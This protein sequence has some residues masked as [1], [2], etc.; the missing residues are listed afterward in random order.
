MNRDVLRF[1]FAKHR[2]CF[3]AGERNSLMFAILRTLYHKKKAELSY[4]WFN[5]LSVVRN[6]IP[7]YA[8]YSY[9]SVYG[10]RLL[11]H[12]FRTNRDVLRFGGS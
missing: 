7:N 8:V 4:P 11:Y 6:P 1:G 10:V 5:V 2:P 3:R 12:N 9:A